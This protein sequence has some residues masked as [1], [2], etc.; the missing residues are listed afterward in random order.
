M[1]VS[2]A[3][4]VV[5]WLAIFFAKVLLNN[6][7]VALNSLPDVNVSLFVLNGISIKGSSGSGPRKTSN[8][9]RNGSILLCGEP[10][11]LIYSV[12]NMYMV[13]PTD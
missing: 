10:I 5:G 13:I 4:C 3:F 9:I 1:R 12:F 6:A 11:K 2:S 7:Y 8:G